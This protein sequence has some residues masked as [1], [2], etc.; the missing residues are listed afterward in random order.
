M[1]TAIDGHTCVLTRRA[2][3]PDH[4]LSPGDTVTITI[5]RDGT[6]QTLRVTIGTEA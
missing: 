5:T 4:E 3:R 2:G 1:I 6:N